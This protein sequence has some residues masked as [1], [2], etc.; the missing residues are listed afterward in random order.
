[1]FFKKPVHIVKQIVE[2]HSVGL[3]KPFVVFF[4]YLKQLFTVVCGCKIILFVLLGGHTVVF[5]GGNM[6]RSA[7]Q[8]F[9][10]V[11]AQ[12]LEQ[13]FQNYFRIVVRIYRKI[14]AVSQLFAVHPQNKRAHAVN[15]AYR[16]SARLGRARIKPFA[17]FV[18]SLVGKGNRQNR[19]RIY[20]R[21]HKV[22]YSFGKDSCFSAARSREHQNRSVETICRSLLL[23]IQFQSHFVLR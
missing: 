5:A 13:S 8:Q 15:G 22:G 11:K 12:L 7:L 21:I 18:C 4:Y 17:H 14:A 19:I 16:H 20:S 10:V 6:I 23:R 2:I 3:E 9:F 1:M